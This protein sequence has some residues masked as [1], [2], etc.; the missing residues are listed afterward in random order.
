MSEGAVYFLSDAHFRAR[1]DVG[2]RERINRFLTFLESIGGAEH[3]YLLGD[4]FDFWFEYHRAIPK[5][6]LEILNGLYRLRESG[7]AITMIGGNHDYWMGSCL[8]DELGARL[9]PDGCQAYHQG[10]RLRLIHG[11]EMETADLGYRALKRVICNPLFIS[12]ARLLHP[13]FTYRVADSL[14]EASRFLGQRNRPQR[15]EQGRNYGQFL[16]DGVDIL[17]FGHFH[18][19]FHH[20][21]GP[22]EALCLGDWLTH[23]SYAELADGRLRLLDDQGGTFSCENHPCPIRKT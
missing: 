23:F 6:C 19:A 18:E 15:K 16:D 2:Q 21:M 14:A 22:W 4:L 10:R 17:I 13:D 1:P 11:D 9:A 20:R 12:A 5:G 8:G 7:T 3:L